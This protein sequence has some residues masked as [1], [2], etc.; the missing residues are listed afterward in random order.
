METV[1]LTFDQGIKLLR[2]GHALTAK[3][4]DLNT[5]KMKEDGTISWKGLRDRGETI[6]EEN[7][8]KSL[9]RGKKWAIDLF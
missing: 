1:S 6:L 3:G 8:I 4:Q 9:F 5:L 7:D 2:E